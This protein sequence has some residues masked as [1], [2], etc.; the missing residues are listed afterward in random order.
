[1]SVLTMNWAR[2]LE[3]VMKTFLAADISVLLGYAILQVWA[4]EQK[5]KKACKVYLSLFSHSLLYLLQ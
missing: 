1:M 2:K 3:F 4:V 5:A